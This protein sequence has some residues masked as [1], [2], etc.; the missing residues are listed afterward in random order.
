M[1]FTTK[2]LPSRSGNVGILLLNN[3]KALH[4]LTLDM[5][6]CFQDVL[7]EWHKADTLKA[8]LIKSTEAKRPAFCAG[9]DVKSVYQARLAESRSTTSIEDDFFYQEYKVNHAIATS[10][11]PIV[12]LW[13][14]VVMGGGAGI[15][16]HGKVRPLK[17]RRCL[18]IFLQFCF[19]TFVLCI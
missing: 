14:G 7:A 16:V 19:Q 11:T 10:S 3:P 18:G 2:V 15:S 17:C 5:I 1:R 8:I 9:G 12:S 13:D 6:H 4:A